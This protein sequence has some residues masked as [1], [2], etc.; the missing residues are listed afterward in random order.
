MAILVAGLTPTVQRTM[1]FDR[2]TVGAVNRAKE[3][4]VTASG[5]GINVARVATLLGAKAKVIQILGGDSGRYVAREL[6]KQGVSHASISAD[7]DAP[8]RMCTTLLVTDGPTTELVEEAAP[9]SPHDAALVFAACTTALTAAKILCCSG[10]LPHDVAPDF[11]ARLVREANALGIPAMVDAQKEPLRLALAEKPFLVKPNREEAAMTLGLQLSGV[12]E[13]DAR[14]AVAALVAAGAQWAMVSIGA[15]GSLLG[16]GKSLYRIVPPTIEAKN[17]IGSGDSLAAGFAVA[18]AVRGLSVPEAA[19]YGTACAA[20][21]A[22][23]ATSGVLR[24]EDVERLLPAGSVDAITLIFTRIP[25]GECNPSSAEITF[26]II[27][28]KPNLSVITQHRLTTEHPP[29]G[30]VIRTIPRK[31]VSKIYCKKT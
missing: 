22:L 25:L 30:V 17:P 27:S 13:T 23:T 21:N 2:F 4:L 28:L 15:H 26:I 29:Y 6:D 9:V 19:A 14:A 3:T 1:R 20:A 8:T 10:S 12:P 24:V 11:Y 31:G 18:H 7:D 16:D 5:K